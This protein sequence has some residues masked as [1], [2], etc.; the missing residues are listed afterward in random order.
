VTTSPLAYFWGDDDFAMGR[1]VDRL[2]AALAVEG[3]VPLERWDLRGQRNGVDVLLGQLRERTATPVMFGG[4][5]LAV[6]SNVG[7]L[8]MSND[9]RDAVL[10]AVATLAPGN[11]L[12]ILDATRSGASGPSKGGMKV[13]KA[14]G[15]AQGVVRGFESPK[16]GGLANWIE[17]EA[18]NRGID[19]GAGAAKELATRIGGFVTQNDADRPFQTRTASSELD[20]L[21][22]RNSS[23]RVTIADVEALVAEATPGTVWGFLDAIG[24]RKVGRAL[25]LLEDLIETTPEPVLLSAL[26]RRIRELIEVGD[27]LSSGEK[28][29]SIARAMGLKE[30]P[31]RLRLEQARYWTVAELTNALDGLLELDAMAKHAPGSNVDDAQWR[32]ACTLWV[33]D[34]VPRRER[35]SA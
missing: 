2:A 11:A 35:R 5:T 18:R 8:T 27:R 23:G 13:S 3:G 26:H 28:L 9:G 33:M 25:N 16:A 21:A 7:A 10:G 1:A 34:H 6:V 17:G 24:E 4:G 20:K 31:A 15:D 14:I 30:Y 19:L 22:L 32:L 12:V 29:P